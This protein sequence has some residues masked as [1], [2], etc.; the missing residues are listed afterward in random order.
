[1]GLSMTIDNWFGYNFNCKHFIKCKLHFQWIVSIFDSL[2]F[3][4]HNSKQML[5]EED[6]FDNV[7]DDN[8]DY[9]NV[10]DVNVLLRWFWQCW[11]WYCSLR[12]ILMMIMF[13]KDNVDDDNVLLSWFDND[14]DGDDDGK[15]DDNGNDNHK[16]NDNDNDN[17][18]VDDDNAL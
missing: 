1:M 3:L 9:N 17:N 15:H 6:N 7:D 4:E 11:W 16:D 2:S 5:G 14:N 13:P 10:A 8:F 12:T 18:D